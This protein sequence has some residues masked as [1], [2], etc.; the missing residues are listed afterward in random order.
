MFVIIA[1]A[2]L[3]AASASGG[4]DLQ[5]LLAADDRRAD[6]A[7]PNLHNRQ[8]QA[9]YYDAAVQAYEDANATFRQEGGVRRLLRHS[10][11]RSEYTANKAQLDEDGIVIS[12]LRKSNKEKL[13]RIEVLKREIELE[14]KKLGR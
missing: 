5:L 4:D 9:S 13:E 7:A 2:L 3:C 12:N 8:L 11:F 1:M 14:K 6:D 10:D